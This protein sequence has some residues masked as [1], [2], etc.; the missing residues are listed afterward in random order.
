MKG[1]RQAYGAHHL[2]AGSD[3][4]RIISW[5]DQIRIR[6]GNPLR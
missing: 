5:P 6:S 3:P 2:L 1:K 4:K